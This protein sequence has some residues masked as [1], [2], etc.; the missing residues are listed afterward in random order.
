[1]AIK[2]LIVLDGGYRFKEPAATD[3]AAIKDFTYITLLDTLRGAG[4]EVTRAHRDNIGATAVADDK[5]DIQDFNF[6]TSVDLLEYDV[7]WLIG[8]H[9]RNAFPGSTVSS[10]THRLTAAELGAI[11]RFMD[12]GGGV[13]ATGDHDSIGADMC[14]HIPRIRTMRAWFGQG[15]GDSPMPADFPRNFPVISAGRADTTQKNPLG[16]Y[17]LDNDGTDENHVYFENQS[18]SIPQPITP[19][20]PTHPILRWDGLDITVY[21]DHMHEGKALGEDDL[22]E[23]HYTLPLPAGVAL[24]F[25]EFPVVDGERE[26]PQIIATGQVLEHSQAWG[27]TGAEIDPA[28]ASAK[29]VNT[30]SVYDGRNVGVGRV[31]TGSTFH[32]YVDINLTGDSDII[33]VEQMDLTGEDAAK[34]QG[35]NYPGAEETFAKIKAVYVNITKWLARFPPKIELILERSTFSQDEVVAGSTFDGAILVT[36]DGLKP[37]QFPGGAIDTLSPTATDLENWAPD[38]TLTDAEG[39]EITPIGVDSDQ[40]ALPD[41][42]Q[43]ITFTYRVRFLNENAFTFTTEFKNIRVDASL[44]STAVAAPLVDSAWMQLVKAANPFMLDLDGGNSTTWLS[45]DV[46]VFPVVAGSTVFGVELPDNASKSQAYDFIKTLLGSITVS[47]F[48]S[49]SMTQADSALSPFPTTTETGEKVY[50]FA[51]ARVRLNGESA[52]ANQVRVFFRIFTSQTTAALTYRHPSGGEPLEGYR[53]TSG[54]SPIAIPGITS[55][56]G[57]WLSFPF[58]SE[59]R[60]ATPELQTDGDNVQNITPTPGSEVSEFFGA[61]IDNNLVDPYLPPTPLSGA[62]PVSLSSLL[63]GEHQCL[64]AQIEFAGTP[65]PDGANPSTSDKLSQRNLAISAIANPG[66]DASRMALHTFEIEATPAPITATF[67]PDELMLEW[68]GNV[69][70]GTEVCIYIP[71]WHTD[72]VIELADNIYS[73]HDIIASDAQS[74]VLPGGGTSYVPIPRSFQ[75]QTGVIMATF[76]VGITK[77]QRFDLVVRQISNRSRKVNIPPG[78]STHLSQEEAQELIRQLENGPTLLVNNPSTPSRRAAEGRG[79]FNLGDNRILYTDLSIFNMADDRAILYEPPDPDIVAAARREEGTWRETIG[80]FQIG[81]PVS[82]KEDMLLYYMR[83]L[84]VFRWRLEMLQRRSRWHRTLSYYIELLARKVQA[85]GG[86]PYTIPATPDGDVGQ[87]PTGGEDKTPGGEGAE[88][89]DV[90]DW[91]D[92]FFEPEEDDWLSDT[93]GLSDPEQSKSLMLSGKVSGLLYDH[94]GDF[95]GFTLETY[96]GRHFRL[97]SRETAILKIAKTAWIERYVVTVITVS[98]SSRRVRRL[99]IRGYSDYQ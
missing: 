92:P 24:G 15:D 52:A 68:A 87:L 59:N 89:G 74:V 82:I 3:T 18:D 72:Q 93:T 97:F 66:I 53:K 71:T 35:F 84:S 57:A 95:E 7:I 30:L 5:V 34:G 85:L 4:I 67:L 39:I 91:S 12:A 46:R 23:D 44:T 64:V 42:V 32:H 86:D 27:D 29:T 79:V 28:V 20:T 80:S 10:G 49:L 8:H 75:R 69:P 21:P 62:G 88:P 63:M 81:I 16:D 58:F 83:L 54:A 55:G 48:E 99:L 98:N 37:N 76:P 70:K 61:L 2:A 50:N 22:I 77:G 56:G 78:K 14:G 9:G 13:F 1:M 43:R 36:V 60:A 47:Q 17:D 96:A 25:V 51:I 26:T 38:V 73:R 33:S 40:P 65:I 94:F 6:A 19:V 31:V 45:S 41:R 90:N 11:S